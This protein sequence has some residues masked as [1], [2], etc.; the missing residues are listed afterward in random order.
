MNLM[1][2]LFDCANVCVGER[3][4]VRE[5]ESVCGTEK[6]KNNTQIIKK[7][8]LLFFGRKTFLSGTRNHNLTCHLLQKSNR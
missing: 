7:K 4:R 3:K 6:H 1:F 5:R 2:Y 8:H